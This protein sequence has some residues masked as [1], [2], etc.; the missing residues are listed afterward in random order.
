MKLV[1][2]MTFYKVPGVG[3]AVIEQGRID[4]VRGY[5]FADIAAI[6]PVT[7]DTRFQAASISKPV[8]AAAALDF[9]EKGKILS[10]RQN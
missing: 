8:A 3:I 9:M 4:W 10:A 2:R 7:P 1:D 6:R 5:G